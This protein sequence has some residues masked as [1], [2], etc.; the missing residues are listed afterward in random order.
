[1]ARKRAVKTDGPEQVNYFDL[2]VKFIQETP[3][4]EW[5]RQTITDVKIGSAEFGCR[6]GWDDFGYYVTVGF[7]AGHEKVYAEIDGDTWGTL[8]GLR[9]YYSESE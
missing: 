4:E 6:Y 7:T 2:L 3:N 1:M 9:Y 5:S 8:Q